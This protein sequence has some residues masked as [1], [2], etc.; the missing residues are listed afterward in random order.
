MLKHW[1]NVVADPKISFPILMVLYFFLVP[2]TKWFEKWQKRLRLDYVWTTAGGWVLHTLVI[3]GI[4]LAARDQNF[5]KI[6]TKPDN[7]PIVI[8]ILTSVFFMWFSMKQARDN[9]LRLER[10]EKPNEYCEPKKRNVL[11]WP[12]LVYIELIAMVL[13]MAALIFWS[14][15]LQ[16]P[17]EEP[18]NPTLAPN[19]SK[20]PWYFLALQEM[21][22]YFDPWLAGVVFPT[23]IIVGLM[24]IP[25]LDTDRSTSGFYS[26][27]RRKLFISL[28]N[29]GWLLIWVYLIIVGTFMRGPNWNFFG[30]F[31]PWDVHKVVPMNNI[32]LSEVVWI[33]LLHQPLPDNI[34]LRE[35]PGIM[36][37][38]FLFGILPALLGKTCLKGF[39]A[40][41]GP[42]R[43]GTFMFLS[44]MAVLLPIKMFLR[45]IM[46]LK[47][48]VTIPGWFNV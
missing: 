26:F 32:D 47:Y 37:L 18:A 28:F 17:L 30:P 48:I 15:A 35:S 14:I 4:L 44:M 12:D 13:C 31:E 29:F 11:V 16:A 39:R 1:I 34:V 25:Y 27:S 36:F 23:V 2:P 10:G 9:D 19:P 38:V 41:M 8:L 7:I 21:L 3:G 20:A 42:A 40:V 5:F 6:I 24:S 33:K 46:S 43:Y 45:W 22:V